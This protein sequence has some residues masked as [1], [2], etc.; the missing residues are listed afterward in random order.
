MYIILLFI[1]TE[2]SVKG[3]EYNQHADEQPVADGSEVNSEDEVQAIYFPLMSTV[4]K[5]LQ[6]SRTFFPKIVAQNWGCGLSAGTCGK[7]AVHFL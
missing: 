1:L 4:K 6:I 5:H 3:T 7:G 2:K